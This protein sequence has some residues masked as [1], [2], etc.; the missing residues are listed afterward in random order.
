MTKEQIE[1]SIVSKSKEVEYITLG[2]V[3]K[4]TG[5]LDELHQEIKQKLVSKD[6]TIDELE[7]WALILPVFSY[8]LGERQEVVGI[9]EDMAKM[10]REEV[11]NRAFL[12]ADG[13]VQAK[14]S[15]AEI[16]STLEQLY[17]TA[18]A[19]AYR[20]IKSKNEATQEIINSIKKVLT[21]AL[22]EEK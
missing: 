22:E 3:N 4:F 14:K 5:Q 13:S 10:V 11:F 8:E 18:Y 21:R 17:Q 19:R 20:I 6:Y 16:Q 2:V 15:E 7:H 9:R 12:D 1:K